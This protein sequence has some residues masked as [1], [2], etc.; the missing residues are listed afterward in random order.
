[1]TNPINT[2]SP[3][4]RAEVVA[5]IRALADLIEND[6]AVPV[7]NFV[8][9]QFSLLGNLTDEGRQ[10]VRDV[11]DHLGL[12]PA[13]YP[14]EEGTFEVTA[15]KARLGVSVARGYTCEDGSF[16]VTYVVHGTREKSGGNA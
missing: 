9:A 16:R 10:L 13:S 5:G 6:L 7:P 2:G 14:G 8:G 12:G 1:M 11:A 3:E 15:D 4:R